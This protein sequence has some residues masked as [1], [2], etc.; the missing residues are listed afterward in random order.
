MGSAKKQLSEQE[1]KV[2]AA[3]RAEEK[4]A[5]FKK[6]AEK[7]M[8]KILHSFGGLKALSNKNA[9]TWNEVQISRITGA[10]DKAVQEV[11]DSFS[12]STAQKSSGFEL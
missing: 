8:S 6:L 9:Y 5:N 11:K 12:K 2:A 1:K 7:R 4:A 10:L 3:K